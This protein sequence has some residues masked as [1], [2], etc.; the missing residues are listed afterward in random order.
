MDGDGD[1]FGVE[2]VG[3][4]LCLG[5]DCDDGD[6]DIHEGAPEVND[7]QDNQCPAHRAIPGLGSGVAS[8][9]NRVT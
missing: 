4:N 6:P 5:T 7:A 3:G 2:G 8:P 1:G 9:S